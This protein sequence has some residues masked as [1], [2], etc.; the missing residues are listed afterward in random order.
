M[1]TEFFMFRRRTPRGQA[2]GTGM[3]AIC[4]VLLAAIIH[5]HSHD[6]AQGILVGGGLVVC[7]SAVAT[8]RAHRGHVNTSLGRSF[9]GAADERDKALM[10]HTFAVVGWIAPLAMAAD[11]LALLLGAP[12]L[13]SA[14]VALIGVLVATWI[15]R[16][17]LSRRM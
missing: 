9:G 2:I 13:P 15:T 5:P 1:P 6:A 16:G 8:W 3:A 10:L 17:V 12:A 4:M 7:L 14:T 11:V